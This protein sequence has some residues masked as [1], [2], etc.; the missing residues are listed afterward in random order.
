MGALSTPTSAPLPD[1]YARKSDSTVPDP[2]ASVSQRPTSDLYAR[3]SHHPVLGPSSY[4]TTRSAP[5]YPSQ[6]YPSAS[7]PD[8]YSGYSS[9]TERHHHLTWI[10]SRAAPRVANPYASQCSYTSDPYGHLT[11][12]SSG[13][14]FARRASSS[15]YP[16]GNSSLAMAPGVYPRYDELKNIFME[17][18]PD[19]YR[20]AKWFSPA[21]VAD[22]AAI[23][24]EFSNG[25]GILPGGVPMQAIRSRDWQLRIAVPDS[26]L[27][28]APRGSRRSPSSRFMEAVVARL[29]LFQTNS[30]IP[31]SYNTDT[32][33]Y[34]LDEEIPYLEKLMAWGQGDPVQ[35]ADALWRNTEEVSQ[36]AIFW[37]HPILSK[38]F[39]TLKRVETLFYTKTVRFERR[40]R[41]QTGFFVAYQMLE[42]SEMLRTFLP[43]RY[44]RT[45]SWWADYEVPQGFWAEMG[46]IY[47]YFSLCLCG[48]S[49][50]LW[51]IFMT[52]WCVCVACTLIWERYDCWRIWC[53]PLELLALIR[54]LDYSLPLGGESV[55]QKVHNL[56]NK[57]EQV[58]WDE[59]PAANASRDFR[60]P[61]TNL[62]SGR[63]HPTAGDYA[64]FDPL[65]GD[66]CSREEA[67]L[68]RRPHSRTPLSVRPPVK[69]YRADLDSPPPFPSYTPVGS[70]GVSGEPIDVDNVEDFD[71]SNVHA[72]SAETPIVS[73]MCP[74]VA[75]PATSTG[76]STVSNPVGVPPS[77]QR[78]PRALTPRPSSDSAARAES[79]SDKAH[80]GVSL[81]IRKTRRSHAKRIDMRSSPFHRRQSVPLSTNLRSVPVSTVAPPVNPEPVAGR[82]STPA[83]V[84][85]RSPSPPAPAQSPLALAGSASGVGRTVPLVTSSAPGQPSSDDQALAGLY[86]NLLYSKGIEPESL[87]SATLAD[88]RV[89]ATM[90]SSLPSEA[91]LEGSSSRQ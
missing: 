78:P 44:V 84:E 16:P 89:L 38:N 12:P 14:R 71:A 67:I 25:R 90:M 57:I 2:Y 72:A 86:R 74:A 77:D 62:S 22:T 23:E 9:F 46:P 87:R 32:W 21:G 35:K 51:T 53:L 88:L 70:L 55:N 65:R 85:S 37:A 24:R 63:R 59:V 50:S 3:P 36:E 15:S 81:S 30:L 75:A 33:Q 29:Q 18:A 73:K 49:H 4:A 31:E 60:N 1:P 19:L 56:L 40:T 11:P 66:F 68:G 42:A 13:R 20:S 80:E 52:E 10:P 64:W 27:K 39:R 28:D 45:S 48:S 26:V 7:R 82:I 79:P 58:N 34:R 17:Q 69:P 41:S 76:Q 47:T 61:P 83:C 43:G 5:V 8:P 6:V 54:Q 91:T